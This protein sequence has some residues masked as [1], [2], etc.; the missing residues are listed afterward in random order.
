MTNATTTTTEQT[1]TIKGRT[2]TRDQVLETLASCDRLGVDGFL[3]ANG[4]RDAVRFHLRHDG[5]SYPSKAILGVAAGL[6]AAEFFGGARGTVAPLARLGFHVR[7]SSTGEIVDADLDGLRRDLL[8]AG[9]DVEERPW[10]STDVAPAAYFLSGSNRPAEI[11]GLAV[12]GADVGVAADQLSRSAIDELARLAGSEVLVFLDSGAFSEVAMIDGSFEIV[13]PITAAAWQRRLAI[14]L[15][16]GRALGEQLVV[17]APDRVGDQ[18]A[19]LAR[20][21]KYRDQVQA[22][23]ATGARI[24]VA[25]QRGE[26]S[27]AA[28]A[29]QIDQV[30][31]GIAWLPAM[32]CKKA[33]TSPAE[34]AEFLAA[35]RPD[36]IHLL[37]LGIR[38]RS[39]AAY[40]APFATSSTSVSLDSCWLA[41]NAG[42]TNGPANGPRRLTRARDAAEQILGAAATTATVT[43]LALVTCLGPAIS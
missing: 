28:F 13:K 40:L 15:E 36:H 27:Q 12:A 41:A 8:A 22:I 30:L 34:L 5:R 31:A 3:A 32:P 16:L 29:D 10:P 2:I 37:G 14:A 21:A 43:T 42:R 25:V 23:A 11:R 24:L 38:S 17:V 39:L 9:L 35:R 33:A 18:D 26:R 7:N 4:Y 1:V 20:L 19:T 6:T